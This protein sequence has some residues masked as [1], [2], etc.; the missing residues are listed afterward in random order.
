MVLR[1]KLYDSNSLPAADAEAEDKGVTCPEMIQ[2]HSSLWTFRAG[3]CPTL[4]FL[5]GRDPQRR[6]PGQGRAMSGSPVA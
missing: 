1:R 2:G 5:I 6:Q 3:L 4:H